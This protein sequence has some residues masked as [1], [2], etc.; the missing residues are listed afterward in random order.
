MLLLLLE[1]GLLLSNELILSKEKIVKETEKL[2]ADCFHL[3]L[4]D[5]FEIRYGLLEL[6]YNKQ[7]EGLES[8]T[9]VFLRPSM[10]REQDNT[11]TF[12]NEMDEIINEKK[13]KKTISPKNLLSI[14]S[15]HVLENEDILLSSKGE[16][17]FVYL[18]KSACTYSYKLIAS[19]HFI[20]LKMKNNILEHLG[21]ERTYLDSTLRYVVEREL[22]NRFEAKKEAEK[23]FIN[24]IKEKSTRRSTSSILPALKIEDIKS[25]LIAIPRSKENQ[26]LIIQKFYNLEKLRMS[27]ENTITVWEQEFLKI[28]KGE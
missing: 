22:K 2:Y 27:V 1:P 16:N 7:I 9:V 8:E 18:D 24:E 21:I 12:P 14:P 10:L 28:N 3:K 17:R 20:V 23:I 15:K 4:D 5:L 11:I 25:I 13:E 6:R 19:H 26:E